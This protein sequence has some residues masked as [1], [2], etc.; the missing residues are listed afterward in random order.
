[1][2][3]MSAA[4]GAGCDVALSQDRT[5]IRLVM[6]GGTQEKR[7][8]ALGT[9]RV[10]RVFTAQDKSWSAAIIKVR[11]RAQFGLITIDLTKC[12]AQQIRAVPELPTAAEF[13]A[14]KVIL[15]FSAGPQT[16]PLVDSVFQ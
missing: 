16:L 1:M 2:P 6:A 3:P 15:T 12:E 13:S 5:T 14:D 7:H 11:G 10:Q 8:I 9:D 4:S